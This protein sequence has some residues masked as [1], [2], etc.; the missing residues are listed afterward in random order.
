MPVGATLRVSPVV[1]GASDAKMVPDDVK[2][3]DFFD[4][5]LLAVGFGRNG[6]HVA[7]H[8]TAVM[9]AP[10]LA[11][12]AAH[13]V[14][15]FASELARGDLAAL[16][17]GVRPQETCDV[18]RLRS[19]SMVSEADSDI[20]WLSL[21]LCSE[22]TDDWY[23][24]TIAMT[25]RT[26]KVGERLTI[27]G[28]RFEEGLMAGN[29]CVSA[30]PGRLLAASG[31]VIAVHNGRDRLLL[32]FPAVEIACGSHGAMS[33][34]AVLDGEGLLL[35]VI[36]RGWEI[37]DNEGPTYAAWIPAALGMKVEVPWPPAVYEQGLSVVDLPAD[38]C[39][40]VGREAVAVIGDNIQWVVWFDEPL[41]WRPD[42]TSVARPPWRTTQLP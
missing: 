13:V 33:G 41:A 5:A 40:L 1:F 16:C 36:S 24:S 17:I 39:R 27:V 14:R 20:A 12:T 38:L 37:E 4:G 29:D 10:G 22:I 21:E 7:L 19:V 23:F 32:P 15:E 26:P 8:G 30:S 35:G 6:E 18:W 2:N 9:I 3:W 31:E 34:G 28:F 25:T 11:V 42:L